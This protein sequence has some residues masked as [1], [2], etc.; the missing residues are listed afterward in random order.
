MGFGKSA[1]IGLMMVHIVCLIY[2]SACGTSSLVSVR[3]SHCCVFV[4]I[5]VIDSDDTFFLCDTLLVFPPRLLGL[6]A[7][8]EESSSCWL[9][10]SLLLT[11]V[12]K[13][14]VANFVFLRS[15]L[16]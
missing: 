5:G 4:I 16:E 9:S 14:F 11:V 8:D 6:S 10:S 13:E 7:P 2:H 1:Q 3:M 12:L 15:L